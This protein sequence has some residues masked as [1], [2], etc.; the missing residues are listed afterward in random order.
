MLIAV[1]AHSFYAFT[2]VILASMC[3]DHC[4]VTVLS[5]CVKLEQLVVHA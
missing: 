5:Q 3:I 1:I 4:L 2:K